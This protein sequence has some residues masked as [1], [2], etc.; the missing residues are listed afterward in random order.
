MEFID[1][2]LKGNYKRFYENLKEIGKE[3][4]KSPFLMFVDAA[5]C[6]IVFGRTVLDGKKAYGS[7]EKNR[8]A[9]EI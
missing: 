1:F 4:H 2:L 8:S 5:F 7:G 6:S 9:G 3:K